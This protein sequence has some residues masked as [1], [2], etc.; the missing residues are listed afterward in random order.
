MVQ[1]FVYTIL[2][3]QSTYRQ[4]IHRKIR[5]HNID[6]SFEMLHIMRTLAKV[7]KANQQE[8]ANMTYKDKSNLSYLLKNMEKRG[9]ISRE[10]DESDKRNKLVVFTRKGREIYQH[11]QN[12]VAEVYQM[13]EQNTNPKHLEMCVKYMNE[14]NESI[15]EE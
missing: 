5:E 8:L 9:Y 15:S 10:E 4:I 12:L 6:I 11:I 13:I 3:T 7:G 2:Q 1:T 14:F